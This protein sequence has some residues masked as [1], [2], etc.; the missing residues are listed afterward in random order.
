MMTRYLIA[1]VILCAILMASCSGSKS[2]VLDTDLVLQE[3]ASFVVEAIQF[4]PWISDIPSEGSGYH[5]YIS[6][7]E[8]RNHV[9]FDSI[10][11]KGFAGK[12][13]VGKMEYFA[14]I[15]TSSSQKEDLIMSN[16]DGEEYGNSP[17]TLL[18]TKFDFG[19]NTCLIKYVEK[20]QVQYY[21]YNQM[22]KKEL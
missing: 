19:E 5:V 15:Q 9:H 1:F 14:T 12:I 11:Y 16:N 7:A 6:I 17:K 4:Q 21:K 10:Y 18:N 2:K 13:V 20:E 3:K 8:N 22:Q